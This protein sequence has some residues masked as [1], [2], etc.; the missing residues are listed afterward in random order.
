[1]LRARRAAIT[2]PFAPSPGVVSRKTFDARSN[3]SLPGLLVR[4]EGD[5]P[6]GDAALDE[7][8]AGA[9]DTWTLYHRFFQR[10]SIDD[11]GLVLVST[12]HYG[13]KFDNAFWDGEQMV[14]G[15]GDLF[16]RFTADPTVIGHELTHGVT[17]Y[18]AGL[19]YQG[20]PGALNEHISDV[21]G[22]MM[23]QYL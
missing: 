2:R 6:S 4:S 16:A 14:Y 20:Q 13:Q 1:M 9:G 7:A 5:P 12:V 17:Q 21:F 22:A 10:D 8:H 19:I 3:E 23:E 18:A 15:D 11:A